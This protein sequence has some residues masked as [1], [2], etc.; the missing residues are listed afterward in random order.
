[1]TARRRA[2]RA[3]MLFVVVGLLMSACSIPSRPAWWPAHD[4]SGGGVADTG[5]QPTVAVADRWRPGE[6]QLGIN[7]YWENTPSDSNAVVRAKARRVLNYAI[8]LDANSVAVSFPFYTGGLR[9]D[10]IAAGSKTPSPARLALLL[11]AA[12]AAGIRVTVRPILNED[13]LTRQQANAW[14]GII[15]PASRDA[16]FHNYQ[17]FILPY[18]QAAQAHHV[19]TFVIA[20]EFNSLQKDTRWRNV[21]TAV[22]RVFHGQL[23]YSMNFDVFTKPDTISPVP[24]VGVDAYPQLQLPDAASVAQLEAGWNA[25]L[26]EKQKGAMPDLVLSEVGIPAQNDAYKHPG[27]WGVSSK[28][29]NLTV[30]V[31]WYEAACQFVQDRKLAGMYWWNV[32]FDANPA[33]AKATQKDRLTF[34]GKPAADAIKACFDQFP[35]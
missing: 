17:S 28:P 30:Q 34:V 22:S 25:W 16:W 24:S 20:T 26:N 9:S 7:I 8:S 5:K 11:D 14:R 33:A 13:S 35:S 6:T 19:A 23:L 3:V 15:E 10:T 27:D 4:S 32:N 1:M 29:L 21:V 12:A 18:A 2:G 31:H